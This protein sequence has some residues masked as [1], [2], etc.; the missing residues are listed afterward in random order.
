MN[1]RMLI[2][3]MLKLKCLAFSS[4]FLFSGPVLSS[5]SVA[6]FSRLRERDKRSAA[7][8]FDPGQQLYTAQNRFVNLKVCN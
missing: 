2:K 8:Q 3:A 1:K 4:R 6:S 7:E 5:Q